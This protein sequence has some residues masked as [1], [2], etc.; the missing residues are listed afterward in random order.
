MMK[1]TF[2]Y[3][4]IVLMILTSCG[5]SDVYFP[6]KYT[7]SLKAHY[8]RPDQ[9]EFS[10]KSSKPSSFQLVVNSVE[11]PWKFQIDSDWYRLSPV[12]CS[13]T[14]DV[15]LSCDENFQGGV[16][17]IGIFYLNSTDSEW[18]YSV[19]MSVIQAGA[20]PA[21]SVATSAITFSGAAGTK[22]VGVTSNCEYNIS[23][24]ASWLDVQKSE[25]GSK[26]SISAV[27]NASVTSRSSKIYL[28]YETAD[29][30][31]AS[32][33]ITQQAANVTLDTQTLEFENTAADC[34]IK[35]TSEASW[36][37]KTSQTWI[38]L[39]P[40][41]GS[42]GE[43]SLKVSVSPNS[44]ISSREGYIYFY[45]GSS[46]V[47]QIPVV[48]KGMYIEFSASSLTM[49]AG[50]DEKTIS[51][52]SNTSWTISSYPEWC[53]VSPTSGTGNANITVKTADN[54]NTSHREG[55]IKAI[56]PGI[57]LEASMNIV[58][59]GKTFDYGTGSIECSDLA[60][61][62]NVNITSNGSWTASTTDSWITV[63]PSSATGSGTLS[64]T[65]TENTEDDARTG[66]ITLTI[67]DKTYEISVTQSG[68]YFTVKVENNEIGSKGGDVLIDVSSNDTWSASVNGSPSWIKLSKTNG[69]GAA[70]FTATVE[71]NP[72]VNGRS[73]IIVLN[74][75]H[76]KLVKIVVSQAARYLTVDHQDV[77][78]FAKGGDSEDITISTDGTYSIKKSASWFSISEK[79]N[80]VFVVTA[81]ENLGKDAREATIVI[82]ETDLKEGTCSITLPVIQ[83]CYGGTFVLSGYG[84]DENWDI[85]ASA[86]A[87][88]TVIG[89]SSDKNWDSSTY[90][91]KFNVSVTGYNPDSNWDTSTS[92]NGSLGKGGYSADSN[93]D[94]NTS[95]QGNFVKSG[96]GSD[97]NWDK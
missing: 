95:S 53:S 39:S 22:S 76:E 25:D 60:Q 44:S 46:Q 1:K 20:S 34:T 38:Q 89:Y 78:F 64:I 7:A 35:V 33:T 29:I 26:L 61:T 96:F 59:S 90:N 52:R 30:S 77:L 10:S 41:S 63:R 71:D 82:T 43:S 74:T 16:Q 75:V 31:L 6:D 9:T 54:P 42:A 66:K 45:I 86:N 28:F 87:S 72:S 37:A 8:L 70:S 5:D 88:F 32:I 50:V 36:T 17:R 19:P 48:Q 93:Y 94:S 21:A 62:I 27:E 97:N 57:S 80:G 11:T 91:V 83:T 4:S 65:V 12:T 18:E 84:E 55:V 81:E 47:V 49:E 40:E 23:C 73:A 13:A 3:I 69:S 14:A 67:G 92:S 79:G 24:S 68:K 58:Q 85:G 15:T 2:L 51:I 56:Q